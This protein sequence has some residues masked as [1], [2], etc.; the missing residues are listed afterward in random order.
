MR[1][2]LLREFVRNALHELALDLDV[3]CAFDFDNTLVT[4]DATKFEEFLKP[5]KNPQPLPTLKVLKS[6]L[7]AGHQCIVLTARPRMGLDPVREFF[8]TMGI[9]GVELVGVGSTA[10]KYKS[11]Y[12]ADRL[13]KGTYARLEFYDDLPKNVAAVQSL[14]A[15][16]PEIEVVSTLV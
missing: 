1:S 14:Q 11:Q 9:E 16:F 4:T 15:D 6:R 12:L 10:A 2:Q 13:S 5:L 7:A 8:E 3:L